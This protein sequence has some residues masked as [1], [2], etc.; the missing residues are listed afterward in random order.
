LTLFMLSA[1]ASTS[2]MA[3][4]H[5]KKALLIVAA[6][7]FEQVEYNNTLAALEAGG[8]V[9][10]V[11]STKSGKLKSNKGKRIDC[12]MELKDV[13]VAGYDAVVI[14]GG[15]GIKK[16]WKNED[17]HRIVREAAAQGKVLAAICAGPGVLA[18]ADVLSGRKA[19]ANSRSGAKPI[20]VD[21]GCDYTGAAV[22]VD[23]LLITANG[24]GAATQYG[25]AIVAALN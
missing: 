1:V 3:S 24:P 5:G 23:G 15:N 14:I 2:A 22:E 21:R 6:D 4:S 7:D 13:V 20:M 16:V 25:E 18:C 8:V 17:A 9:C 12:E 10:T 11:A 19:T